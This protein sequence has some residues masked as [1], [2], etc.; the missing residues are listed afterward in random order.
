MRRSFPLGCTSGCTLGKTHWLTIDAVDYRVDSPRQ[1]SLLRSFTIR[2][3]GSSDRTAREW[4]I[5]EVFDSESASHYTP[6]FHD[7]EG[8][9]TELRKRD[10]IVPAEYERIDDPNIEDIQQSAHIIEQCLTAL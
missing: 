2:L 4:V 8:A 6:F 1:G 7:Y 3:D 10:S 9:R 5:N